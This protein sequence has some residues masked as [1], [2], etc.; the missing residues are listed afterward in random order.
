MPKIKKI[1]LPSA[2][3]ISEPVKKS[4]AEKI[5]ED[6]YKTKLPFPTRS[7]PGYTIDKYKAQRRASWILRVSSSTTRQAVTFSRSRSRTTPPRRVPSSNVPMA[8]T[9]FFVWAT[10]MTNSAANLFVAEL[11]RESLTIT[12]LAGGKELTIT[13]S[14]SCVVALNVQGDAPVKDPHMW[15][16]AKVRGALAKCELYYYSLVVHHVGGSVTWAGSN[17]KAPAPPPTV[18]ALDRMNTVLDA[19]QE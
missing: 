11:V 14:F 19:A 15:C 10:L 7:D 18:S 4:V 1:A 8:H 9:T 16:M 5:R 3:P 2:L 12:A 13:G 17:I 6:F